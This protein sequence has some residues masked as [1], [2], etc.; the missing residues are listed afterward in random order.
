MLKTGLATGC[1][2]WRTLALA[3]A[4]WT[5]VTGAVQ[6]A[7]LQDPQYGGTAPRVEVVGG[8]ASSFDV[9]GP[10][11]SVGAA[12]NGQPVTLTIGNR[13]EGYKISGPS[14]LPSSW[15][16]N[17][18]LKVSTRDSNGA[19]VN[20]ELSFTYNPVRIT[21]ETA[22]NGEI[23]VPAVAQ[24]LRDINGR[25]AV[26]TA[27]FRN[28]SGA[29]LTGSYEVRAALKAG[30]IPLMVNGTRIEPGSW[31]VSVG[32]F[33][34]SS[35]AGRLMLPVSVVDTGTEGVASL[36]LVT[37]APDAPVVEVTVRSWSVGV[38]LSAPTWTVR[39]A[40]DEAQITALVDRRRCTLTTNVQQARMGA[41]FSAPM[42]LFEWTQ[43]PEGMSITGSTEGSLLRG[44]FWDTGERQIGYRVSIYDGDGSRVSL[45]EGTRSITVEDAADALGFAPSTQLPNAVY[46]GIETVD[47]KLVQSK[48]PTC[49]LTTNESSAASAAAAGRLSCLLRWTSLPEG[50]QQPLGTAQA[51][52]TG[53]VKGVGSNMIQYAVDI[54]KPGGQRIPQVVGGVNV[55]AIAPPTPTLR[56]TSTATR[57]GDYYT[58]NSKGGLVGNV[59]ITAPSADM[60]ITVEA[61]DTLVST[62][63]VR[64]FGAS[65]SDVGNRRTLNTSKEVQAQAGDAG[66]RSTYRVRVAYTNLP[67]VN[68]TVELPVLLVPGATIKPVID[69]P[70]KVLSN[71]VFSV[72]VAIKDISSSSTSFSTGT[73]GLWKVRLLNATGSTSVPVSEWIDVPEG[74]ATITL[75]ARDFGDTDYL[76]FNAEAMLVSDVDGVQRVE[77][78]TRPSVITV[79]RAGPIEATISVRRTEGAVPFAAAADVLPLNSR[80]RTSIGTVRWSMS[81]DNGQTWQPVS[82]PAG[83]GLHF[84]AS[85]T[86][87]RY[88][89]KAVTVN[90]NDGAEYTTEPVTLIAVDVLTVALNGPSRLLAGV[91]A[92]LAVDVRQNGK[93]VDLAKVEMVWS[94]DNGETWQTLT[95]P[96]ITVTGTT[97]ERVDVKV[98][99][100]TKDSPPE[101]VYAWAQRAMQLNFL[102]M[103]APRIAIS[104]PS[105]L[106]V[107]KKAKL[108]AEVGLPYRE[109]TAPIIGHWVLP[110]GSTS[111]TPT[112]EWT[113]TDAYLAQGTAVFT[114]Q[115]QIDGFDDTK[116]S[117]SFPI[118]VWEYAWPTF[119][120]DAVLGSQYAPAEISLWAKPQGVREQIEK[121]EGLK[122]E[123]T[124]PAEATVVE[125][126]RSSRA[127]EAIDRALVRLSKVGESTFSIRVT[128]SR[129]HSTDFQKAI[130]LAEPP[131][132]ALSITV[133]G[134]NQW[135]RAPLNTVLTP[136]ITGGH[137][138]DRVKSLQYTVDGQNV[139]TR[140]WIGYATMNAGEHRV[141]L[142]VTTNFGQT[143]TA[144]TMFTVAENQKP[145]CAIVAREAYGSVDLTADCKDN[146]GRLSGYRWTVNGQALSSQGNRVSMR[147]QANEP[148]HVEMVGVD[149]SGEGS[150]PAV[151]D[152]ASGT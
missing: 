54:V 97:N 31:P 52:L 21:V 115:A 106:E 83:S 101:S 11:P 131:P 38:S 36:L 44:R 32:Q 33:N 102:G 28:A 88:Q 39:Q 30:S 24:A 146:D 82:L 35:S 47:L 55:Q 14:L 68:A 96:S 95:V 6:G 133:K 123:W 69:A 75:N 137:P 143:L 3:L 73:M 20:K 23:A 26:S 148:L 91:P 87:G 109:V 62:D 51:S 76:R 49:D 12:V 140:G 1:R 111:D 8:N 99:A 139:E 70:A 127:S 7:S 4:G 61:D 104:G 122:Y 110:D 147:R 25:P 134:S 90:V 124:M 60:T 65:A 113:A 58:A 128:D 46:Q 126:G 27:P 108:T 53:T 19:T 50:M 67:E 57:A 13:S 119:V 66:T 22:V 138:Q 45:V 74:L 144:E 130:T 56:V 37:S 132:F 10:A 125:M 29:T 2:A 105:A 136:T 151:W 129:G 117:A 100:R 18:Q 63:S 41:I 135:N 79:L 114:Y 77:G 17:Y 93:A 64:G 85:L 118:K 16:G 112:I 92:V 43:I 149:D 121:L 34:F 84:G 48:G 141:G 142:Q 107:G 116:T 89:L 5:A 152:A 98:K 72:G 78:A 59:A 9:T 71:A 150:E 103:A 42:C 40:I 120:L 145:I 15:V 86:A 81:S 80:A 94:R